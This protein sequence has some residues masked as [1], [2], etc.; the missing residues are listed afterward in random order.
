M[1]MTVIVR[2]VDKNRSEDLGEKTTVS[3]EEKAMSVKK[4]FQKKAQKKSQ[5]LKPRS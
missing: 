4:K 3:T 5:K 1:V 2:S